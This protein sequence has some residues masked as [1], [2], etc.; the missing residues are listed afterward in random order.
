MIRQNLRCYASRLG[1]GC[2][3]GCAARYAETR[4]LTINPR[5]G[6]PLFVTINSVA[7]AG[8]LRSL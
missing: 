4:M 8:D 5:Y 6:G 1:G 7:L 3:C 2:W